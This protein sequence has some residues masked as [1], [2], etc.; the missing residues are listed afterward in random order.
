MVDWNRWLKSCYIEL[1]KDGTL[2]IYV[3]SIMTKCH[4]FRAVS[5]QK[6]LLLQIKLQKVTKTKINHLTNS[7]LKFQLNKSSQNKSKQHDSGPP[8]S[9]SRPSASTAPSSRPRWA[10]GRGG[11]SCTSTTTSRAC[12]STTGWRSGRGRRRC[13]GWRGWRNCLRRS[14]GAEGTRRSGLPTGGDPS[15][16][17]FCSFLFHSPFSCKKLLSSLRT[18]IIFFFHVVVWDFFT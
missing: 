15:R 17:D 12:S 6:F 2:S 18:S 9:K 13:R 3:W 7:S 5:C 4:E 16:K 8:S 1:W 10:A 14:R 11:S